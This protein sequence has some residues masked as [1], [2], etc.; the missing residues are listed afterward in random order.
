M[1]SLH[2]ALMKTYFVLVEGKGSSQEFNDEPSI[3]D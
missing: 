1:V 3:W 2:E